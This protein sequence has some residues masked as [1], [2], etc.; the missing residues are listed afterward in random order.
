MSIDKMIFKVIHRASKTNSDCEQQVEDHAAKCAEAAKKV[1]AHPDDVDQAIV[2]IP[3]E[4]DE[5]A[6]ISEQEMVRLISESEAASSQLTDAT[7]DSLEQVK[8]VEKVRKQA[9]DFEAKLEN[10][11]IKRFV[12]MQR[13]LDELRRKRAIEERELEKNF[14]RE[15]R[16]KVRRESEA[17]QRHAHEQKEASLKRDKLRRSRSQIEDFDAVLHQSAHR[18]KQDE[19]NYGMEL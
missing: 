2:E 14:Q 7:E 17:K 8:A 4:K 1:G 13:I 15:Q 9:D 5:F 6:K 16:E 12:E 10:E 19:D 3:C 11:R 18:K